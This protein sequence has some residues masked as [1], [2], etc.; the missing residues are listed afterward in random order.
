MSIKVVILSILTAL[1][2]T[3]IFRAGFLFKP[4]KPPKS[5]L[6]TS[7]HENIKLTQ[8]RLNRFIGALNIPTISYK[9]GH[10][11]PKELL[12]LIEFIE[13]EFSHL[14]SASFVTKELVSNFS[15]VYT[16]H[17]S[18]K[19]LQP[20]MLTSHLDVVPVVREKWSSD[21]FQA[22]L[23]EDN[24]I[25]A[26][27]TIDA[28]HLLISM[29][30]AVEHMIKSGFIPKRTFYLVFGHDEEVGG[31]EGAREIAKL[32]KNKLEVNH[33]KQLEYI[34]DE[35][36]IIT[37]SRF[38]GVD[39]DVALIGVAEK[40]YLTVKVS[41][42]GSFGHGSMPPFHTAVSK[43]AKVMSKF[44][45]HL[46]PSFFGQGVEREMFDI[47]ASHSSWPMKLVYANFWLFKPVL[48][49]VFSSNP[50]LNALI[51][52]STAVTMISGGTK[53]NVLPD[54]A[55]AIIN[56]RVHPS[57]SIDEIVEF[58]K[59]VIKDPTVEVEVLE[60]KGE[61]SPTALYCDDCYGW[62]LL[63]QSLLQVYP[64]TI[65]VPSTFLASSD[66]KWYTELSD[67][68]FKFSAIV[69]PFEE[70]SRFHGHDERISRDNYEGLINFYHHLILNGDDP[71]IKFK[72]DQ[73]EEL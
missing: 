64:G 58:D 24:F 46:L 55:S 54:S 13:K 70:M 18:D 33:W 3:V 44:N 21:P 30:E 53:E 68:I 5:C 34:L 73:R 57:Q 11:E 66:S 8:E 20:Y 49:Y 37:S 16:L 15:L 50:T 47:I 25:Y 71:N 52:T 31:N 9:K 26:R 38:P 19:S 65:V 7:G 60:P 17:G 67:S 56:H 48:E 4:L 62:Q 10:Y 28:K 40:G 45:S 43:L 59:F 22:T 69:V 12:R 23:K 51:R 35:G 36:N 27:G 63:R 42:Q 6:E 61:P 72:P 14:N 32:M 39:A 2:V 1:V 41:T 29:L